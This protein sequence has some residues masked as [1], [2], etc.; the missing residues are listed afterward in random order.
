MRTRKALQIL[1]LATALVVGGFAQ[2]GTFTAFESVLD[3]FTG[4]LHVAVA[5]VRPARGTPGRFLA[6]TAS[7]LGVVLNLV[8]RPYGVSSSAWSGLKLPRPLPPWQYGSLVGLAS[9]RCLK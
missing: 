4:V 8:T 5:L 9:N 3:L 7:F 1:I 6:L 2:H